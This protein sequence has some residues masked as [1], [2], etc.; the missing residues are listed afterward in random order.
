MKNLFAKYAFNHLIYFIIFTLGWA[1]RTN[2]EGMAPQNFWDFSYNFS[3]FYASNHLALQLS[4][5]FILGPLKHS[6]LA[7]PWW[8]GLKCMPESSSTEPSTSPVL[9]PAQFLKRLFYKREK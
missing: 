2:Q 7:R 6:F 8:A 9:P 4:L 1:A 3:N 5:F